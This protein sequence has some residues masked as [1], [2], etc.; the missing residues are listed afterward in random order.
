MSSVKYKRIKGKGVEHRYLMEQKIGRKLLSHECVH[1]INGDPF[2]NR[3][4]NLQLMT[5]SE[6]SKYHYKNGDLVGV[7]S[8][9]TSSS[10]REG[11]CGNPAY[12]RLSFRQ[13]KL[14]LKLYMRGFPQRAI[15]K[16]I[17]FTRGAVRFYLRKWGFLAPKV[18]T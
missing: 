16:R 12:R 11:Q 8:G 10:W 6:H 13:I 9:K 17:G 2:D 15:A 7:G 14:V 5:K 18:K 1:H 3:I 4:E